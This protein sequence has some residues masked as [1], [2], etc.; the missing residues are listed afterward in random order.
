M[1]RERKK[2]LL[3]ARCIVFILLTVRS[4]HYWASRGSA[5]QGIKQLGPDEEDWCLIASQLAKLEFGGITSH[6]TMLSRVI[7]N[8]LRIG[9]RMNVR[10]CEERCSLSFSEWNIKASH[11][12]IWSL[13]IK[14]TEMSLK[15][16]SSPTFPFLRTWR[17]CEACFNVRWGLR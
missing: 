1:L 4:C 13:T 2:R 17:P 14:N 7:P 3:E 10:I 5:L 9:G 12:C 16:T 15:L 8:M 6:Q 11:Y